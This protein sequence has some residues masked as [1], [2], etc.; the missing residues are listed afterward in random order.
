[1]DCQDYSG[2]SCCGDYGAAAVSDGHGSEKHFRS[3]IGAEMAVSISLEA[4]KEF[5]SHE[6]DYLS[7][8][9]RQYKT[10]LRHLAGSISAR[11]IDAV[12]AHF[13]ENP[14]AD[15]ERSAYEKHYP[16]TFT[17]AETNIT[18]IY[19]ATLAIAVITESYAFVI[20]TGD[21]AGVVLPR[22]GDCFIPPETIDDRLF[23]GFTTSL[24]D[25][26]SLDNFRFY[27]S[28]DTPKAIILSTDGV[29]D[30]YGKDEFLKFNSTL[31][32]LFLT[33]YDETYSDLLDWLPKL[34]ARGSKDDMS[35]A[36]I[37]I[38]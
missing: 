37:F 33:N 34:S 14:I 3:G 10:V 2:F 12:T 24:C 8:L 20:Q 5:T 17:G 38:K 21:G 18:G 23:M 19:G 9:A 1:M 22:E 13:I 4:V 7:T 35:V 32:D 6:K 29:V 30:S 16:E 15:F 28:Q 26:N 36:G 11:W 27:Y 25:C 31:Y